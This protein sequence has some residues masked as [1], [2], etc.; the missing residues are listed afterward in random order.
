MTAQEII[1]KF[2]AVLNTQNY[3]SATSA[4]DEAI[5]KSS[6]FNGIQDALSNFLADQ[7]TA[8]RTAIQTILGDNYK[9][10]YDGKQ[11]SDL[12]TMAQTDTQL[13]AVLNAVDYFPYDTEN[14]G[15]LTFTATERIRML[16]ANTFLSDYCGITLENYFWHDEEGTPSTYSNHP[17]GNFD[18]GAITGSDAGGS[19][20]K[21]AENV[22]PEIANTYTA[23]ASTPQ[24]ITVGSN[25]WIV[26][27]TSAADTIYSGGTDSIDAGSGSDIIH[28]AGDNSTIKTGTN[29]TFADTVNISSDVKTVTI[30]DLESV[31]TL[32]IEGDFVAASAKLDSTNDAVTITDST[33]KRTFLINAWTS[34]QNANVNVNGSTQKLGAW[35]SDFIDYEESAD[36]SSAAVVVSTEIPITV[37]LNDVTDIGGSFSLLTSDR[38]ASYDST[39]ASGTVGNVSSEFPNLTGFTTHGLTV[40][41]WGSSTDSDASTVTPLTLDTMSAA[42]KNIFAALYKWWIKEGL[43][44]NEDSFNLG[45]TTAGVTGSN[46]KVFFYSD[47]SPTLAFVRNHGSGFDLELGINMAHYSDLTSDDSNGEDG[48][49]VYLD[50][51]IAHELTHAVMA[52]NI[53]NF[54]S[55]PQF[56]TEGLAELVHGID[57]VRGSRIWELAGAA[58]DTSRLT[59]ALDLTDTGTGNSDSYAAGYIFLRYY[60]RHAASDTENSIPL[61]D[62][63]VSVSLSGSNESYFADLN[64]SSNIESA[65]T[66]ASDSN[67]S[68][69]TA[70]DRSYTLAAG[71]QQQV[72]TTDEDWT[73]RDIGSN[74]TLVAGAGND[75]VTITASNNLV[76]LGSG[77]NVIS[78][79][80]GTNNTI[81]SGAGSDSIRIVSS[82]N[83]IQTGA[84]NDTVTFTAYSESTVNANNFVDTGDGADIVLIYNYNQ[85]ISGGADNDTIH[86]YGSNNKIDV[87]AGNDDIYFYTANNTVTGGAGTDK[88][89]MYSPNASEVSITDFSLADNEYIHLT[90]ATSVTSAYYDSIND[91]VVLGKSRVYIKNADNINDYLGLNIYNANKMTTLNELMGGKIFDWGQDGDYYFMIENGAVNIA[92]DA[93]TYDGSKLQ[94]NK[95]YCK[96]TLSGNSLTLTGDTSATITIEPPSTAADYSL[97]IGKNSYVFK[98]AAVFEDSYAYK[99]DFTVSGVFN[100]LDS[101]DN[102]IKTLTYTGANDINNVNVSL[103]DTMAL[104]VKANETVSISYDDYTEIYTAT[105][106]TLTKEEIESVMDSAGNVVGRDITTYRGYNFSFGSNVFN[107]DFTELNHVYNDYA[108]S[109]LLLYSGTLAVGADIFIIENTADNSGITLHY[110]TAGENIVGISNF[111]EGEIL[112]INNT[113]YTVTGGKLIRTGDGQYYNGDWNYFIAN[114]AEEYYWGAVTGWKIEDGQVIYILKDEK[115]LTISGLKLAGVEAVDGEIAGVT[116]DENNYVTLAE[117]LI[118]SDEVTFEGAGY[119]VKYTKESTT[120]IIGTD[121]ADYIEPAEEMK[122]ENQN[123]IYGKDG[124]DTISANYLSVQKDIVI[125]GGA[126]DD[127]ISAENVTVTSGNVTISG[128]EGADNISVSAV[129]IAEGALNINGGEGDDTISAENVTVTSGNV[130]I[131]GVEGA[132]N[133]SVSAVTLTEGNIGIWGDNGEDTISLNNVTVSG[134][135]LIIY[136]DSESEESENAEST[137]GGNDFISVTDSSGIQ[138]KSGSGTD[139]LIFGGEVSATVT[140]FSNEDVISLSD[141]VAAAKYKDGVLTLGNI[142]LALSEID[143]IYAFEDVKVINGT[144]E[145]TLGELLTNGFEWEVENGV[146]IYGN[147]I[148]ITG[149]SSN[150]TADD[151]SLEDT[152]VSISANALSQSNTV[153]ITEGY[154]LTLADDVVIPEVTSAEWVVEEGGIA[155]YNASGTTAGYIIS[156][157]QIVYQAESELVTLITVEGLSSNASA[158]NISLEDTTVSISA[159]ALSEENIVTVSEG[160]TLAL[161]E[162]VIKSEPTSAEWA[163]ANGTANYNDAGYTAGYII[164]ENQIVYQNESELVT[165]ITVEGLS[166]NASAENISLEDT[167][168][169]ISANA[170]SQSNTVK[171]T[172]GYTLALADDV[173]TPQPTN[174]DWSLS[175]GTAIFSTSEQTAGYIISNNQI[176]YQ[177]IRY[178]VILITIS[179]LSSAATLEDISLEGTTVTISANALAQDTVTITGD[180]TFELADDVTTPQATATSWGIENGTATYYAA[181]LSAGYVISE[182]QIVYQDI[183]LGDTLITIN[184]LSSD[185]TVD[186]I[187]L[188]GINVTI[189]ANALTTSDVTISEGYTLVLGSNAPTVTA[190]ATSWSIS[191]GTAIY[192]GSGTTAGYELSENQILYLE[193]TEGEILITINGLSSAATLEDISFDGTTV[194][195]SANAL[196]TGNVSIL[197]NYKLAL[198]SDVT[199]PA[200]TEAGWAI[201]NGTATYYAPGTSEGYLLS[202]NLIVY[203]AVAMGEAL[204][205]ITGLSS[206]A[207]LEDISLNGKTVTISANAL[208]QDTVTI[209]NGYTLE[210]A[211]DVITPE[212][213]SAGWTISDGTAIYNTSGQ[214]AGYLLSNNKI[215]YKASTSNPSLITIEGLSTSATASDITLANKNVTLALN[216]LAQ[217]TI[218]ITKGYN[219][220]LANNVPIS[221]VVNEGWSISK[222]VGTYTTAGQTEG[223]IVS[224]NQ[225]HYNEEI[226]YETLVTVTGLK[227]SATAKNLSLKGNTVS[228]SNGIVNKG[229]LSV[230]EGY[231]VVLSKG[232]YIGTT[233]TGGTGADTVTNN[234]SSLA[235]STNDGNDIITLGSSTSK[236]TITGGAGDDSV[237]ATRGKNLYQYS[238]GDGNDVINGFTENDTLKIVSGNIDAWE[239]DGPDVIFTVGEGSIN[240]KNTVG[241]KITVI[242]ANKKSSTLI[243]NN[244][245]TYDAKK[246]ALQLNASFDST[247]TSSAYASSVVTLDGSAATSVEI[248]GNAKANKITGG[249]GDDSLNGGSGND[250]LTGGNGADVFIYANGSGKDVITDYTAE[251]SIAIS[252]GSIASASIKSSDVVFKVGSGS[253]TVKNGKGQKITTVD[254]TGESSTN[255]YDKGA[256]Y[257][258]DKTEVT[259]TAAFK[260]T[261][262]SGIITADGSALSNSLRITGNSSDNYILGGTKADTLDGGAGNDTLTGGNGK[263]I[264]V[265]ASSNDLITDYTESDKIKISDSITGSAI[266]GSDVILETSKGTLT[267]AD[268][269]SK[270]ITILNSKNKSETYIFEDGFTYNK[271][272]TAVTLDADFEGAYTASISSIVTID[273]TAADSVSITGN[274]K[275]NKIY[276]GSGNDSIFGGG[277]KNDT[278]TGGAGADVFVYASGGG[279]DVITDYTAEDSIYISN[280][281][282]SSISATS[283]DVAFKVGSGTL[284]VKKGVGAKITLTD[285][286]GE[287]STNI[288]EKGKIYNEN[289]TEVTFT[290][291]FKGTLESGVVTADGSEL[292]SALKVTGNSLDNYILGGTKADTLDGGKGND[293]L[294]GGAGNDVFIFESGNDLITDYTAGDKI[295]FSSEISNVSYDGNDVIFATKG[296]KITVADGV[297]KEISTVVNNKTTKQTYTNTNVSAS[298]LDLLDD[299]NFLTDDAQISSITEIT[300]DNYSVGKMELEKFDTLAQNSTLL[301]FNKDK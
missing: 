37:N 154:T 74:N 9:T 242:D 70:K 289:K 105:S 231:A 163:V 88:Y 172:E 139:T 272:Q 159:N 155:N 248:N 32:N 180:Y 114:M 225:I 108:N 187:S 140:D 38:A 294:T 175:N 234:G 137:S 206:T 254:S 189:Y 301:T 170:L 230:S 186:D 293:T 14:Y 120:Y 249:A 64:S 34:S 127:T 101:S 122:D 52:A 300:A 62:A 121:S 291:S 42:Q 232:T 299:T 50:R 278:L 286:S 162:D 238:D 284:T 95:N 12:L 264:F 200:A 143:D 208:A 156:N 99:G 240:L 149:L 86:T 51:T 271:K 131:S 247:L 17:T 256:V 259:F 219:L 138:I 96:V 152:T 151:I 263:D 33:G 7:K 49:N 166:S 54:N 79:S 128:V 126:G 132:D 107:T 80:G 16:A 223:Y 58:S 76:S 270:K 46:I 269:A 2:M 22:I 25:N 66:T 29:D 233:L 222:G 68:V 150:A 57:D 10:E 221:T 142:N 255:I 11:L 282:I 147:L 20:E 67:F 82:G 41:L 48:S 212:S 260:G 55:L 243:Y 44:L 179:G 199:A 204:I 59:T 201:S 27:A 265:Y 258:E 274:A 239:V 290:A 117:D 129:T 91:A 112:T 215:S 8:E 63:T 157:N 257:N 193:P 158:E 285:S 228:I 173:T 292:S 174:T 145:T 43:Q 92:K 210:L 47:T 90:S 295:K 229:V 178:G 181:G 81:I 119:L 136:G 69:G 39:L 94:S 182:N 288:Y 191:R 192:R 5:R 13:A 83:T 40:E 198:A 235:I 287:T 130:T 24:I 146:A 61:G 161:A 124:D 171:V 111:T 218:T 100:F 167:T 195:I 103:G 118:G 281:E 220:K 280:G 176:V 273:G 237:T 164:S 213:I 245:F 153:N 169:S 196:T 268:G 72:Y 4:L 241:K 216:A 276:G 78:L 60:A 244:G 104:Y 297:G 236:N 35:L 168:V 53:T 211:D 123:G 202:N 144:A 246:T 251:D 205:K 109:T 87:G 65:V 262:E 113:T 160:Y 1:K 19:A 89:I 185:A 102:A 56:I 267:V 298:T 75:Y 77:N 110:D 116:L 283:S 253:L 296:G 227:S 93:L 71:I 115:V 209:S 3:N 36:T 18:T 31:D 184:G 141:T 261:L 106:S 250:T 28:V 217:D 98:G 279:K 252:N 26:T 266:E 214:S 135:E 207:T 97:S 183:T 23:T 177:G 45:F 226:E 165:L 277:S 275:A 134:G 125:D 15:T 194:T 188:K 190:T 148:T 73:I 197:G 21:T 85:T 6:R 30:V 203:K 224:N 84:G 133:I